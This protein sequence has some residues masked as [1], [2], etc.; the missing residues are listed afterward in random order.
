MAVVAV[1]PLLSKAPIPKVRGEGFG[2]FGFGADLICP[3]ASA[4]GPWHNSAATARYL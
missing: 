3:L 2:S 4:R 1:E